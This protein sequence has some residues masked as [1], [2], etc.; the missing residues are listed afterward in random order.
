MSEIQKLRC[1]KGQ[2]VII[3]RT[4]PHVQCADKFCGHIV[5]T[6]ECVLQDA[7][8][9]WVVDRIIGCSACGKPANCFP[10]EM[11]T[12]IGDPDIIDELAKERERDLG[13]SKGKGRII[14]VIRV[15][16][17]ADVLKRMAQEG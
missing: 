7:V 13:D 17:L 9:G 2:M 1:K 15:E 16:K 10:D 11:L 14:K 4:S 6:T 5:T 3:N 8:P 12:P